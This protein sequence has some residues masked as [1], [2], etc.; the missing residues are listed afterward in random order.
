M[1]TGLLVA[2]GIGMVAVFGFLTCF[3]RRFGRMPQ[4]PEF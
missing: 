2:T 3:V 1:L 4:R